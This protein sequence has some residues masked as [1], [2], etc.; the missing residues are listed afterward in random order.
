VCV[1]YTLTEQKD[2]A[3]RYFQLRWKLSTAC[4]AATAVFLL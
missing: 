2:K 4:V 3:H 1:S